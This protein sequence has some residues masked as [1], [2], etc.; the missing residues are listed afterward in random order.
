MS[1]APFSSLV[2]IVRGSTVGHLRTS[3]LRATC[4]KYFGTE[5]VVVSNVV[6]VVCRVLA[7]TEFAITIVNRLRFGV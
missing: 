3:A 5:G 7:V 1:P 6:T 2:Q 4:R